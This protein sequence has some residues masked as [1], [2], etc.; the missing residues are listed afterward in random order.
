MKDSEYDI[1]LLKKFQLELMKLIQ[2]IYEDFSD[3]INKSFALDVLNSI[4]GEKS[5]IAD[6]MRDRFVF[7]DPYDDE[8]L[9]TN[10]LYKINKR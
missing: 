6:E 2:E 10:I 7:N 9:N 3:E 1:E 8:I 5:I 4:R